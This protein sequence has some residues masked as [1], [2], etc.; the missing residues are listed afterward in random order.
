MH[1]RRLLAIA[2]L[3]L[4]LALT[5]GAAAVHAQDQVRIA[6]NRCDVAF[7]D[8]LVFALVAEADET[9]QSVT[10]YYRRQNER[11][12]SRVVPEFV[13]GRHVEAR[14]ERKLERGEIPPGTRMEYY[15]RLELADGT[16]FGTDIVGF[17]YEDDRFSW[18]PIQAGNLSIL[19]YGG[20]REAALARDLAAAGEE[21]LARL[22][23]EVG[24]TLDK[25]VQVYVYRN[26]DDMAAALAPRS[27]GFDERILTLGVAVAEDTLLLLG[28]HPGTSETLA[29][30]LSHLVVGLATK[31][32]YGPLPRWLDEGLAMYAEGGL[33]IDN[34]RALREAVKRDALISV[35]S[36]SGYAGDPSQVDLYYG[37]V[38]SL[39]EFLLRT[40]GRDKM[41]ELLQVFKAGTYQEDALQQVY[42]L[43]MD[44]LDARWRESLG[45][46]ARATAEPAP[47]ATALPEARDRAPGQTCPS[48]AIAGLLGAA[49]IAG[50]WR[51]WAG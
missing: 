12:T 43:T 11:V 13:P 47:V 34:A 37:E 42:G 31:N 33:P 38:Y 6:T 19:H 4:A 45:L 21:A 48:L 39:V 23:A 51:G 15:W 1:R 46:Q 26:A 30:E 5:L 32:P 50:R 10:L 41:T 49:A 35:R 14:F 29:H 7:A 22:Q 20:E 44:E 17:V 16:S 2:C 27:A 40:Y 24:V 3:G 18:Q 28:D 8:R 25:P 9:I 36:L